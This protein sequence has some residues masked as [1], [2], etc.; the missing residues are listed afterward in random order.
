M[1]LPPPNPDKLLA[2]WMEWEKGDTTPG[3]VLKELKINGMRQVLEELVAA[4]EAQ[5]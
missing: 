5:S 3:T 2:A 4:A 1:E